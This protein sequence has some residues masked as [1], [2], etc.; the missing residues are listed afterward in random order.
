MSRGY[1]NQEM[2]LFEGSVR[3]NISMWNPALP[4]QDIIRAA[5][6]ACIHEEISARPGGYDAPVSEAGKNFSGGQRQRL[7]IAKALA[8]N[9]SLLILDEATS[10]LDPTQEQQIDEN[11][12]RRGVTCL[13]FAH[14]LSTIRDSDEIV[15]L[16]RG[17][18]VERGTPRELYAA[19]GLYTKLVEQ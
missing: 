7:E 1:V 15:V 3:D 11:L 6:D 14:R 8:V 10:A 9:P 16:D 18:I 4:E 12:R 13:I 19:G 2:Y 17:R 5:K